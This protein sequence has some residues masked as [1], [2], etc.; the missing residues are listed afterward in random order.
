[1]DRSRRPGCAGSTSGAAR[2][3]PARRCWVAADPASLVGI[4]PSEAYVAA[5]TAR[6]DDPRVVVKVGDASALPLADATVDAVITGLVLNFVPDPVAAVREIQRVLVPG[7][8]VVA[9]VWDYA[10]GMQMLR[11]FWDAAISEDPAAAEHDEGPRFAICRE[12]AIE[13]CARSG[14]LAVVEAR[15][16]TVPMHFRDFDDF[17]TPFLGG[18]G[19]APGY[20]ASL[21]DEAKEH[22]RERLRGA[23]PVD[24][25]GAIRLTGTAWAVH[26]TS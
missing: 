3:R 1:M 11:A 5:A 17:W 21:G 25:D 19:P 12:G 8:F 16:V 2:E 18:Q 22:L 4:D 13:E 14:G 15:P 10:E 20:V 6:L 23:L 26:A 7:G 24:V 9:Y